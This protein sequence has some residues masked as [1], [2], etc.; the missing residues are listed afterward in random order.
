MIILILGPQGSGKGTQARLLCE[1]FNFYYFEAGD[2][3]RD[4]S[5]RNE[6]V[7][8]ILSSGVLVPDAEMSSY[9]TSFL[10]SKG[11]YD[12]IVFD[13]FPRTSEQYQVLKSWLL[14]KKISLDLVIV[15]KISEKETIRRLSARRMDPSTGKIYNLITDPPPGN[16]DRNTLVQRNDDKPEAI[17]KRLGWYRDRVLPL[18][19]KLKKESKVYEIDGERPIEVIQKDLVTLLTLKTPQKIEIMRLGGKK[20]AKIKQALKEKIAVGVSALE[21]EELATKLIEEEGAEASFKKVPRYFWSTCINVNSGLVH[22]IPRAEVVFQKGDIVSVDIGLFYQG[23]HTDCAFSVCLEPDTAKLKFIQAGEKAM[24]K[25]IGAVKIGGKIGDISRAIE[26]TVVSFGYNPI[27]ALTGHG[28]GRSLHEDPYI[29]CYISGRAEEQIEIVTGIS[30][31][32]EV[33]YAQGKPDIAKA[34]DGWTISMLDGKIAGLFEET[35]AV[36]PEGP[37]VLTA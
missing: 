9:V 5:L 26:E 37:M 25:A 7:K 20:L 12:D 6:N 1:K 8:K 23:F 27:R 18:I 35:V 15:L 19:E 13:G 24:N 2:F 17:K 14:Q 36:T 30:L 33:M 22:G 10:D 3:L 21:I 31:A 29:P 4:L 34:G 32:I 11:L 28:I 16:V